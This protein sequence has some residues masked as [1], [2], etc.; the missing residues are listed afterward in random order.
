MPPAAPASDV[1]SS[2]PR[3]PP[4][5]YDDL[6]LS[7]AEA[8]RLLGEGVVQSDSAFHQPIVATTALDG[9]A[10][11][12]VMVLRQVDVDARWLQFHSDLRAGKVH[13]LRHD[14]RAMVVAYDARAKVQLRVSGCFAVHHDD[15][16]ATA[17][18]EATRRFS[19]QCYRIAQQPGSVLAHPRE[20]DFQPDADADCGREHFAVLRLAVTRIEWLYLAA[21]G[22]RRAAFDCQGE[23]WQLHWLTP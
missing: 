12:R 2:P 16:V 22:H 17:A 3:S 9:S 19:R 8:W 18:W 11:A 14:D 1:A 10:D 23:N 4:A 20:A 5:L 13:E 21:G 7:L 6:Q 15:T